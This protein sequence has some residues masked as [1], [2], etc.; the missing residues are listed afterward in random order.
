MLFICRCE[1]IMNSHHWLP[2]INPIMWYVMTAFSTIFFWHNLI[3]INDKTA[4]CQNILLNGLLDKTASKCDPDIPYQYSWNIKH[5]GMNTQTIYL[6]VH[7]FVSFILLDNHAKLFIPRQ[8][9]LETQAKTKHT[10]LGRI[11]L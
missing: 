10:L 4:G 1:C 11:D 3:G 5:E 9:A 8:K 6:G 2:V 7:F